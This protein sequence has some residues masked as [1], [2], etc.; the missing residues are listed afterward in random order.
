MAFK[1]GSAVQANIPAGVSA[2][3]GSHLTSNGTDSAFW[4]YMGSTS[5]PAVVN[6][7]A[8]LYRSIYTHG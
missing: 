1:V 6:N 4:A 7:A 5:T 3:R 8:W 2:S